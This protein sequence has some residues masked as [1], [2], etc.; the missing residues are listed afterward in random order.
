M[1]TSMRKVTRKTVEGNAVQSMQGHGN[2]CKGC[3]GCGRPLDGKRPYYWS[4]AIAKQTNGIGMHIDCMT[5]SVASV[6]KCGN[7]ESKNA[8]FT[9]HTTVN[10]T[11]LD[12]LL[13]LKT[14]PYFTTKKHGFYVSVDS[15]LCINNNAINK[16]VSGLVAYDNNRKIVVKFD[17][18]TITTK[19]VNCNDAILLAQRLL[20]CKTKGKCYNDLLAQLQLLAVI[21]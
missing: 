9:I 5:D 14:T 10:A 19:T 12:A 16:I 11:D 4:Y 2:G 1:S 15:V 18:L 7:S 3:D 13:Y 8:N 6:E 20:G 21:E 17:G